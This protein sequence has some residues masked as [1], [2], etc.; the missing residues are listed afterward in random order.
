MT[1]RAIETLYKGYRFR[2]RSEARF[3]VLLDALG[4]PWEYEK[5]GYS[6]P[7][8]P[9]LPDFWVPLR[10]ERYPGAG[11][12]VEIKPLRP[13]EGEMDLF[14]ELVTYTGHNGCFLYGEVGDF[15]ALWGHCLRTP[16]ALR[17]TL[18]EPRIPHYILAECRAPFPV[19]A[20]IRSLTEV[21]AP[22]PS[23][24]AVLTEGPEP[25]DIL[26]LVVEVSRLSNACAGPLGDLR[27]AM[28]AARSARFEH[29]ETPRVGA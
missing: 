17:Q 27:A 26:D 29:G 23:L 5:Q 9:Y 20:S 18:A 8:G 24:G 1:I 6:L 25:R 11:Y 10:H 28:R 14:L 15:R 13:T 3:A 2:S 21:K 22:C 12:W 7:S 19:R 4:V 16:R